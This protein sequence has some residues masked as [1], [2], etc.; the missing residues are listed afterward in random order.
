MPGGTTSGFAGWAITVLAMM[1]GISPDG[2]WGVLAGAFC[3]SVIFIGSARDYGI[4][5]KRWYAMVSFVIGLLFAKA[6]AHGVSSIVSRVIP[7]FE[8]PLGIGAAIGSVIGVGLLLWLQTLSKN[9]TDLIGII[10][11]G[12]K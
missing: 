5:Q 3:G 4:W 1:I 12:K 9:P 6:V 8:C 11:G 2:V 7:G 10:K